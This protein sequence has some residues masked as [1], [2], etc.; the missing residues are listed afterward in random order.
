M[1][2]DR[3]E[4]KLAA[5]SRICFDQPYGQ[6]RQQMVTRF[7]HITIV[8]RDVAQAK[9]FFA[10]L[11]FLE[12]QSVVIS[13]R[14]FCKYMG[15]PD[16]EAEHITLAL[17]NATPRV[18]VQLLRYRHPDPIQDSHATELN[19]LG[20]NH[21]CFAVENVEAEVRRLRGAGIGLRNEI[22]EFHDRKLVFLSGPE[23]ITVELAEWL[24]PAGTVQAPGT[25]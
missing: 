21:V 20:F 22:M 2:A 7:D 17:A 14:Q 16:I 1:W 11:G 8:V 9:S 24:T 15:I 5:V 18:E 6:P 25:L 23:G 13:G 10:Q 3:L 12:Q 4:R 19:K